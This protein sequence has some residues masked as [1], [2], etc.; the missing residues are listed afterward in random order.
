[1]IQA[2]TGRCVVFVAHEYPPSAGGGV[3]RVAKLTRYL[4]DSGYSPVVITS[5]PAWGRATDDT[6]A[7]EVADVPVVR[8]PARSIAATVARALSPFKRTRTASTTSPAEKPSPAAATAAT[9]A[10]PAA[11]RMPLS[12]RVSRWLS[13]PDDAKP[14]ADSAVDAAVAEG[15]AR[16]AVAVVASGPPHSTLVAGMRAAKQLGVPFIADMRDAWLTNP[17]IYWPSDWHRSRNAAFERRVMRAAAAVTA[18]SDPIADEAREFGATRVLTLPNGYDANDLPALSP[19]GGD[20]LRLGFMGRFYALTDP[21]PLISAMATARLA[22]VDVTLDVVGPHAP[23][24][25][26]LVDRYG[27]ADAVVEHGYLPHEEALEVMATV[28]VGTV[29]IADVEGAE[30]VFTGKLFEYLGMGLFTLVVGPVAGA[31]ANLVE[32]VSGGA[33]AAYGDPGALAILLADLASRK[34][35]GPLVP[36]QARESLLRFERS[37]Q[38][39]VFAGLLDEVTGAAGHQ[40]GATASAGGATSRDTNAVDR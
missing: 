25:S 30:A 33:V 3:Q 21:E 31:A 9:A 12:T 27:V 24:F 1:M 28:D 20:V 4:P 23:G 16:G 22:G 14:W 35:D 29:V 32:E 37:A 6:L 39:R 2:E 26:E 7:A 15:R 18:V 36:S 11:R 13:V 8:L 40:G 10:A 17:S 19:T 5:Q 38:A 34:A